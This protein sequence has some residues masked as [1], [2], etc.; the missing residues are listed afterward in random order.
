MKEKGGGWGWGRCCGGAGVRRD[1]ERS[2]LCSGCLCRGKGRKRSAGERA[3]ERDKNGSLIRKMM[4]MIITIAKKKDIMII[5]TFKFHL[6]SSFG[7]S[8]NHHHHNY[9]YNIIINSKSS[10]IVIIIHFQYHGL[11]RIS[12]IIILFNNFAIA[13]VII[14]I[15]TSAKEA[16]FLVAL[17]C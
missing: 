3:K 1:G 8:C 2:R 10:R 13:F 11:S 14:I 9:C 15:I 4:G 7:T 6:L 5:I 17:V 12:V 16:L